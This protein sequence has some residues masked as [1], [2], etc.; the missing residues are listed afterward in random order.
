[1]DAF[2]EHLRARLGLEWE[3]LDDAGAAFRANAGAQTVSIARRGLTVAITFAPTAD[4]ADALAAA[5]AE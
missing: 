2:L 3:P 5:L 4:V 1:M